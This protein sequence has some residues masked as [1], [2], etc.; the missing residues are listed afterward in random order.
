MSG[1]TEGQP[2][3]PYG[4]LRISVG[5]V[6]AAL[7]TDARRDVV[8]LEAGVPSTNIIASGGSFT[9]QAWLRTALGGTPYTFPASL[10]THF[11]IHDLFS[12]AAAVGS[13]FLG[14]APAAMATPTGDSGA[15]GAFDNVNWYS[16]DSPLIAGLPDGTYKIT[17]H[18]HTTA[19]EGV[20]FIHDGT[21]V[22]VG[23]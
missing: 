20:M 8:V 2:F 10:V 16:I 1:P 21:I 11:H 15:D 22:H 9:L 4:G 23:V 3:L 14:G 13:P 18:G 19:A 7:G 17:V 5:D 12:G 6:E